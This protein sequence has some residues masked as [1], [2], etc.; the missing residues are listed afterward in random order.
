[1]C[2]AGEIPWDSLR[3]SAPEI[4][5]LLIMTHALK[6]AHLDRLGIYTWN[7]TPGLRTGG[8]GVQDHN[9][10]EGILGYMRPWLGRKGLH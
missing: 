1:V 9:E 4:C 2:E 6:Y 5:F 8:S 10:F 7:F 3:V